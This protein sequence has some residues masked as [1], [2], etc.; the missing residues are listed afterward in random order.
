MLYD[1]AA[2]IT[3][4]TAAAA[5]AA[6]AEL[7]P[8]LVLEP[9]CRRVRSTSM[10]VVG[11][12][13]PRAGVPRDGKVNAEV[14]VRAVVPPPL[15]QDLYLVRVGALEGQQQHVLE[16]LHRW[17]HERLGPSLVVE[18]VGGERVVCGVDRLE[19]LRRR[20]LPMDVL[21]RVPLERHFAEAHLELLQAASVLALEAKEGVGRVDSHRHLRDLR[22][23]LLLL[24]LLRLHLLAILLCGAEDV[25][26][27]RQLLRIIGQSAVPLL[28]VG[29]AAK[30]RVRHRL[31]TRGVVSVSLE[32]GPAQS[33]GLRV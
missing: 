32:S 18:V 16:R 15:E 10:H 19:H 3:V 11:R 17:D 27:R 21:V 13:L 2:A 12:V 24:L 5:A 33:A 9:L 6:V 1:R 25:R 30:H 14:L 29:P 31:V 28:E 20:L 23:R 22:Q 26:H 8:P 4:A 7:R